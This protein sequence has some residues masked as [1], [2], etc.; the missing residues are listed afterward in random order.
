VSYHPRLAKRAPRPFLIRAVRADVV[1]MPDLLDDEHD[2]L[3]RQVIA[4]MGGNGM[5]CLT[6]DN[7]V[8]VDSW[9]PLGAAIRVGAADKPGAIAVVCYACMVE[10][11]IND[12]INAA[13]A[14]LVT[15]Q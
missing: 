12:R 11:D 9:P 7:R 5:E 2:A 15:E 8:T 3:F 4:A 6:C 1:P 10:P 14:A 13:I